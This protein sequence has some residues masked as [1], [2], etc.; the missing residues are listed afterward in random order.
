MKIKGITLLRS[1]IFFFLPI[2]VFAWTSITALS[3]YT[4]HLALLLTLIS[5]G[6]LF[7]RNKGSQRIT[8]VM[9]IIHTSLVLALV[10]ATAWLFSPF[11]FLIYLTS[12]YLGFLFTPAIAFSFLASLLL[13]FSSSV[14]EIN[15]SFDMLVL[16]S[17]LLTIPLIVYLRRKY[18]ILRQTTKDILILED[19]SG[20]KDAGTITRLLSNRIT[21]LGV[22]VRQ[23]LTFIKQA[24]TVLLEEDIGEKEGTKYLKRIRATAAETL[25]MIRLF[26]GKTSAN[27]VLHNKEEKTIKAPQTQES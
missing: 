4:L 6:M 27:V 13:I 23:P 8:L 14:G 18:L 15:L 11:F 19:E 21:S 17:L 25:D 10:G 12:L 22:N 24:A 1:A 5:V 20:I 7:I 2:I 16:L 3:G 26:E 9:A